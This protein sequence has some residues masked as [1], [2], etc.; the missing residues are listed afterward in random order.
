VQPTTCC[1]DA[2]EGLSALQEAQERWV[3]YC[4]NYQLHQAQGKE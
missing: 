2:A 1:G 4:T 3:G